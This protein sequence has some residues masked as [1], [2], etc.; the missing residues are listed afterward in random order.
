MAIWRAWAT[1]S[2]A[3]LHGSTATTVR[4]NIFYSEHGFRG[5]MSVCSTCLTGFTSDHNV[6]ESRFT[7]DEAPDSPV[8]VLGAGDPFGE[9]GFLT[10]E[11]RTANV[12][13][14]AP[15]EVLVLSGEFL[16]RFVTQEP[17]IAA[18]ALLN[19]SRVLASRLALTTR[20]AAAKPK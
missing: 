11:P 19:L 6:V 1:C 17:A 5:A 12:V 14:R 4:N 20:R 15:C 9:I 3:F 2:F 8:A 16:Q 13:A 7:L 10:S 18:K